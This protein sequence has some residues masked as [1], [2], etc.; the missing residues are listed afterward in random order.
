VNSQLQCSS[1]S[2]MENEGLIMDMA[3]DRGAELPRS[4]SG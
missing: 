1:S 3:Q 4:F 2:S